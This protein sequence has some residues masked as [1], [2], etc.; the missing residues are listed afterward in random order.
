MMVKTQEHFN[1]KKASQPGTGG[2]NTYYCSLPVP[3]V[4]RYVRDHLKKCRLC[5]GMF[6]SV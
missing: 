5:L 4:T 2:H 6:M 1:A 3:F